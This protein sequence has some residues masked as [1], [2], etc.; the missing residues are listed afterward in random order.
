MSGIKDV[1]VLFFG[2]DEDSVNEFLKRNEWKD[3]VY[4]FMKTKKRATEILQEADSTKH[5]YVIV[6]LVG[7]SDANKWADEVVTAFRD[8]GFIVL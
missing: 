3:I 1:K 5:A 8:K 6:T 7:W 2:I 4:E